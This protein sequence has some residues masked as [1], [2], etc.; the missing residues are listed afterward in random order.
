[1]KKFIVPKIKDFCSYSPILRESFLYDLP[2]LKIVGKKEIINE[3]IELK[4]IELMNSEYIGHEFKSSEPITS[5]Y[6][7]S[8]VTK[9][10]F[11]CF[12]NLKH[13]KEIILPSTI[14]KYGNELFFGLS[15]LTN[16]EFEDKRKEKTKCFVFNS[17]SQTFSHQGP[18][19]W[20]IIFPQTCVSGGGFGMIQV[21]YIY[22]ALYFYYYYSSFTLD[23]QA[24]YP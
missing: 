8:T 16:I 21:Q 15:N 7:P 24:L 2:Q 1:M 12:E 18:V 4:S 14:V 17:G 3:R 19:L 23:H 9:L 5:L 6:I 11:F 22:W 13:L 20:K 10:Q